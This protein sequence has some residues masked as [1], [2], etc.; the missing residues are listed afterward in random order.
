MRFSAAIAA[1][2]LLTACEARI[3]KDGEEVSVAAGEG[4]ASAAAENGIV[5]IDVPGFQ[6]KVAIPDEV[7]ART[8]AEGDDV[9]YPGSTVDG[10]AI[11]GRGAVDGNG[12]NLSFSSADPA[13]RIAAWYRDPARDKFTV[14]SAGRDGEAFVIAAEKKDARDPDRFTIRLVPRAGGGTDGRVTIRDSG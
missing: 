9:V 12:V 11:N 3:G 5:S 8:S 2:A 1:L 14:T 13:D 7:R 4:D 6:M 10:I